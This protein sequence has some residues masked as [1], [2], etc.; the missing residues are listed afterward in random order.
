MIDATDPGASAIRPTDDVDRIVTIATEAEYDALSVTQTTGLL[1]L[2]AP[3]SR[4]AELAPSCPAES[5]VLLEN[6]R[7]ERSRIGP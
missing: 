2:P 6:P 5:G 4:P 1:D 7:D 3:A